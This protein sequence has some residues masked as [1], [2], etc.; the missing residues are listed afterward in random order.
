MKQPHIL[1]QPG[2]LAERAIVVGDPARVERVGALLTDSKK[3]ISN[4]EF[5]SLV[6]RYEGVSIAVMST[7]IGGPSS[8][9]ALEEMAKVGVKK[10][11]R[12]GSCGS[13]QTDVKVGDLVIPQ[14]IISAE[15]T[16]QGYVPPEYPAVA[17]PDLFIALRT[18]AQNNKFPVHCGITLTIDSLYAKSTA[19]R[20]QLWARYG[21]LAQEME[22]AALLTVGKLRSIQVGGVFLVV[23]KVSEIDIETGI[24]EYTKQSVT[25]TGDL[26]AK[27]KTAIIT[28][29]TALKNI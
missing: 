27:E 22:G 9:I 25:K 1:C 13:M 23:N 7:G 3:V 19:E 29:L 11:V 16:T 8:A 17:D 21:A 24:G 5:T 10:V 26:L 15:G 20:K 14:G 12:V 18:A 4:R 6:G 28:A 2:D